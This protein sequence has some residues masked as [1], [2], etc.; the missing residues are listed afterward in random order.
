MFFFQF[1]SRISHFGIRCRGQI[2]LKFPLR[3]HSDST[4]IL[5]RFYSDST[6]IVL[7]WRSRNG[8]GTESERNRNGVNMPITWQSHVNHMPITCQSH[9]NIQRRG[10]SP[11]HRRGVPFVFA[12]VLRDELCLGPRHRASRRWSG[13]S[14]TSLLVHACASRR[15]TQRNSEKL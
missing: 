3:P 7:R 15:S 2:V 4:Q 6:Q 1:G 14:A 12:T 10:W 13:H 8:V 9:A 11:H 5:L